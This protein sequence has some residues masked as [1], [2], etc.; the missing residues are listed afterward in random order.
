MTAAP[1]LSIAIVNW[2]TRGLLLQALG[3]IFAS[4][5]PPLEVIVVDNASA[6]GSAEAVRT[7]FPEVRLIANDGNMGYAH[8]NN[9]A[10][11]A[12]RGAYILLLNPDVIL[13]SDCLEKAVH[14]ME[15]QPDA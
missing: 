6:D 9:Q 12:S 7:R 2:N 10:I 5:S 3:S 15:K 1:L 11:R 8:G 4:H 13:P 14:F